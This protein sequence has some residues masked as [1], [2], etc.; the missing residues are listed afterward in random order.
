LQQVHVKALSCFLELSVISQIK[1]R[2]EEQKNR[3][4]LGGNRYQKAVAGTSPKHRP[5]LAFCMGIFVVAD[6]GRIK[7]NQSQ[8][9]HMHFSVA[10]A[11]A[12]V[13]EMRLLFISVRCY[14]AEQ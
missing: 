3:E 1:N 8:Q 7:K 9:R 2:N 12:R 4:A 11:G 14:A 10:G 13:V 6:S 5:P